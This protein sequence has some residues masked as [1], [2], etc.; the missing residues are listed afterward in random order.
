MSI[1]Q[2]NFIHDMYLN[3]PKTCKW[4]QQRP[5]QYDLERPNL[6]FPESTKCGIQ[7]WREKKH[8]GQETQESSSKIAFISL[9]CFWMEEWRGWIELKTEQFEWY[10]WSPQ[11]TNCKTILPQPAL[12][13]HPHHN[14]T[15]QHTWKLL[16]CQSH[17]WR[18]VFNDAVGTAFGTRQ[19][20][21]SSYQG[22]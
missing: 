1:N 8:W 6:E 16:K 9:P 7:I 13:P 3:I 5:G 11:K 20:K 21:K 12:P 22:E 15:N 10:V 18:G 14:W 17:V 2:C 4:F 19:G